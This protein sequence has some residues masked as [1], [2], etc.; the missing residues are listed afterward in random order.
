MSFS[1][2]ISEIHSLLV[3]V[4]QDIMKIP[5]SDPFLAPNLYIVQVTMPFM[6]LH[7]VAQFQRDSFSNSQLLFGLNENACL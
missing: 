1:V 3:K 2:T 4:S 6:A 5:V 7:I